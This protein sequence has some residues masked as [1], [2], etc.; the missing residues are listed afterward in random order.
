M[1]LPPDK[2]ATNTLNVWRLV[3]CLL[4]VTADIA[5]DFSIQSQEDQPQQVHKISPSIHC[6]HVNIIWGEIR[7]PCVVPLPITVK[8]L[9]YFFVVIIKELYSSIVK[10]WTN[11]G[12][13]LVYFCSFSNKQYNFTTNKCEK[14][15]VHPVYGT[16]IRTH[17]LW[18][19]SRLQ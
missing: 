7:C 8:K 11:P 19:M 17:D 16:G 13:F 14:C 10:K 12:L 18:N 4:F 3:F 9:T 5:S 6:N 2:S 15:Q 1:Q